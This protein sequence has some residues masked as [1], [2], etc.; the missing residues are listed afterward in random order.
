MAVDRTQLVSAGQARAEAASKAAHSAA[1]EG[2]N[3]PVLDTSAAY[4]TQYR[5]QQATM[6]A[7]VGAARLATFNGRMQRAG[8]QMRNGKTLEHITGYATVYDV[9][10]DMWDAYGPYTEFVASGAGDKTLA[11]DPDVMFLMNHRGAI[12]ARTKPG[13]SMMPTLE[14]AS[15]ATGM[16]DDAYVNPIRTDVQ[17]LLSAIEDG[18]MTEQS[19]AFMVVNGGWSDDFTQFGIYE[20]DIDR[21]DVSGVN[22]GANPYT[23]IGARAQE[24]MTTIEA[25]PAGMARAAYARLSSRVGGGGA[26]GRPRG[27]TAAKVSASSPASVEGEP[28]SIHTRRLASRIRATAARAAAKA[29]GGTIDLADMQLPWYVIR[30]ADEGGA[31]R[32]VPGEATVFIFDEIGGSFGVSAKDFAAELAALD[33]AQLNVRINSPGGSLFDGIAI[34]NAINHHPANVTVYVDAIAAS[35]ASVI[36]M[37]GDEIVM[38]PGSQ[39]M[40]HDAAMHQD[41]NAADMAKASTFLDRQSQNVAGIYAGRT[42]G[43]AQVWR[44]LMLAETWAFADEAVELGLADRAEPVPGPAEQLDPELGERMSRSFDLSGFRF[45]GRRAAP[46]PQLRRTVPAVSVQRAGQGRRVTQLEAIFVG[47]DD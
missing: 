44:E 36:A 25:M 33:V 23:S 47:L 28:D 30:S 46:T 5:L 10:Y 15:D 6:P 3:T 45:A 22:F 11:A 31:D 40:V 34:Y 16:F 7:E 14:L 26:G 27:G 39:M 8:T 19:F 24:I 21:G 13:G 29:D 35:A 43:D 42:G 38:M 12:M 41:G 37:A 18:L 2:R 17:I 1:Q 32:A 4:R 9:E 20:Y